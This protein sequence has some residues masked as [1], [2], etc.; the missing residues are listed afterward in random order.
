MKTAINTRT[1]AHRMQNQDLALVREFLH[2]HGAALADAAHRLGGRTASARVFL[3]I[4]ALRSATRLTRLQRRQL[5]KFH[6]LLSLKNVG[7]P[8]AI[9]TAL[10]AEID[11][12]SAWVNT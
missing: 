7:D 10:F 2:W 9:E 8:D 11:P 3:L 12:A 5:I 6:E 4:E 1:L